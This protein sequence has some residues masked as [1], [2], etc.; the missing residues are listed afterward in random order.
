MNCEQFKTRN[1]PAA[2]IEEEATRKEIKLQLQNGIVKHCPNCKLIIQKNGGCDR[3]RCTH[4][5][6]AFAWLT[7]E[8]VADNLTVE[9]RILLANREQS[10]QG[11]IFDPEWARIQEVAIAQH[12]E[13]LA[14]YG[15]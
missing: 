4:C 13:Q 7:G 1:K 2:Q 14:C 15:F 5:G 12:L 10:V 3:M 8:K 6:T 11:Y 9:E